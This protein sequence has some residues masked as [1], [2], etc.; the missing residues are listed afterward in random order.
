MGYKDYC[1]ILPNPLGFNS[2]T[3]IRLLIENRIE[4]C[5]K[6]LL[7]NKCST[8]FGWP[9]MVVNAISIGCTYGYSDRILYGMD[10]RD[11]ELP[12]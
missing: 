3:F 6:F 4:F 8:P 5:N 9:L 11:N 12:G 7:K 10:D 2:A 1:L